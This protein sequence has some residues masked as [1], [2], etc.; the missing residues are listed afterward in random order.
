MTQDARMRL[1]AAVGLV[2]VLSGCV[3]DY[4]KPGASAR[5]LDSDKTACNAQ[6][7]QGAP[8]AM[9]SSPFGVG[10]NNPANA[11]CYGGGFGA[12]TCNPIGP[13]GSSYIPPPPL[14]TDA[15]GGKRNALFESCMGARGW[16]REKPA[17]AAPGH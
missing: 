7:Y 2:A 14:P 1:I 8:P 4:Y 15:N 3:A 9:T 12:V 11:S 16:S 17:Q 5:D 6:A 13:A 10:L